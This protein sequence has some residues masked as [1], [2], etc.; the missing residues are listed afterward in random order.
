MGKASLNVPIESILAQQVLSEDDRA[1]KI[2]V[3]ESGLQAGELSNL[4]IKVHQVPKDGIMQLGPTCSD[5][6]LDELLKKARPIVLV[7]KDLINNRRCVFRLPAESNRLVA[8]QFLDG[9]V[10][11]FPI[12]CEGPTFQFKPGW[13]S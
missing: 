1:L 2:V 7:P 5:E 10:S 9:E 3:L 11:S 13:F 8:I 12:T 4:L 6:Q